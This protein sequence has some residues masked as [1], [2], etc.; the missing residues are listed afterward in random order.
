MGVR[1]VENRVAVEVTADR[2]G[3]PAKSRRRHALA[4][5]QTLSFRPV[6]FSAAETTAVMSD[7]KAQNVAHLRIAVFDPSTL[8]TQQV[9]VTNSIIEERKSVPARH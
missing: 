3:C 7:T 4:E 2:S 1:A 6:S 5:R 9:R 8:Q